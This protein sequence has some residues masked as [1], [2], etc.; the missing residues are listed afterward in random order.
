MILVDRSGPVPKVLLGKRHD[1]TNSCRESS[2]FPGGRMDPADKRM[3]VAS[4][5][6]PAAE[7]N[8]MRA[9]RSGRAR[10]KARGIRARRDPRDL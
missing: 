8:L 2:C 6:H 9:R 1:G 3:P 10:R 7:A 5:L 4:P